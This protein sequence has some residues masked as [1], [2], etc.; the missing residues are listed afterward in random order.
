MKKLALSGLYRQGDVLLQRIARLPPDAVKVDTC[1]GPVVVTYGEATGHKH[2]FVFRDAEM[3]RAG[4]AQYL[5]TVEGA[6]MLHEEHDSA[7]MR[8]GVYKR[9]PQMQYTPA[10]LRPVED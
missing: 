3:F 7:V 10:A 8:K 2:Q 9:I 4:G 6:K 5:R 1:G